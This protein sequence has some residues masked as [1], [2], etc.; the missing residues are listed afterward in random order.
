MI[1]NSENDFSGDLMSHESPVSSA[2]NMRGRSV[3]NLSAFPVF[4]IDKI[5]ITESPVLRAI[6]G[7]YIVCL[8]EYSSSS[9]SGINGVHNNSLCLAEN[10]P[11]TT[12]RAYCESLVP[13]SGAIS[14]LTEMNSMVPITHIHPSHGYLT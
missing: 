6:I 5:R 2:W 13:G 3:V 7:P 9:E 12:F 4:F 8:P 11:G 14:F 1:E 10:K